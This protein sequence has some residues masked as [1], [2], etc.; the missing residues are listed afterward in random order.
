MFKENVDALVGHLEHL[1]NTKTI[2]G[3][4]I[5]AGNIQIIPVMSASFG[6]GTGVG[7]SAEPHQGKGGGGGA[8]GA[9]TPTALVLIQNGEAKVYSL[10]KRGMINKLAELVPEIMAKFEKKEN[11]PQE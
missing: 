6:Y 9:V 3:E 1:I 4:P 5:T 10:G 11:A 7:E 8:G 2:I